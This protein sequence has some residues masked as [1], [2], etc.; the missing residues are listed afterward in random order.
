ML[1]TPILRVSGKHCCAFY[2]FQTDVFTVHMHET[3][4]NMSSYAYII[5]LSRVSFKFSY[6]EIWTT[7]TRSRKAGDPGRGNSGKTGTYTPR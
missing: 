4:Q 5:L 6:L 2:L 1:L 7:A 3:T